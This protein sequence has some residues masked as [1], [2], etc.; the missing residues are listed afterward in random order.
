LGGHF[1]GGDAVVDFD[2]GGEVGGLEIEFREIEAGLRFGG[3]VAGDAVLAKEGFGAG[4][5]GGEG[6]L[7]AEEE[8]RE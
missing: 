4:G 2:P 6:E 7:A 5:R 1:A 8:E 3:A